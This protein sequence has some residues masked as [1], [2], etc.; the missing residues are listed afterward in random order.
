MV[1]IHLKTINQELANNQYIYIYNIFIIEG[2]KGK[3][4]Y[5]E[6]MWRR[7]KDKKL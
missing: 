3:E 7:K 5:K 2:E 4:L 6:I 1:F